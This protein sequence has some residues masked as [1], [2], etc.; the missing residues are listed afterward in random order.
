MT[1]TKAVELTVGALMIAGILSLL[2]L[3]LQVSG[4]GNFFRTDMAGYSVK[5]HFSNIGGL[6]IRAK[7][8]V[9]GVVVGRVI[10]IQLDPKTFEAEVTLTL[11]PK[12]N[13]L[14]VDTHASIMTSGLLGDNYIALSPGY[15]E[16]DFLKEGGM[17]ALENTDSA[18]VLEQLIS[19]FVANQANG[20]KNPPLDPAHN[21][22]PE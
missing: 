20:P 9:A 18:L 1:K 5:A 14:P 4:L 3:A 10:D 12:Q 7:V 11:D 22:P 13:R 21:T 17:I 2:M 6:K 15:D 16:R 19:K 8:S